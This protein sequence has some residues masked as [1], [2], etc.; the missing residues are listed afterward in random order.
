VQWVGGIPGADRL[1]AVPD[2]LQ[3]PVWLLAPVRVPTTQSINQSMTERLERQR[4]ASQ[5]R[6][7]L[8]IIYKFIYS[9]DG[10]GFFYI[11]L[12]LEKKIIYISHSVGRPAAGIS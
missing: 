12:L 3:E 8:N 11:F 6:P 7:L 1:Y 9:Q 5:G 4:G 10:L 2:L